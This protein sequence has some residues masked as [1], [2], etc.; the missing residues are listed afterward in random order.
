MPNDFT[1]QEEIN[2]EKAMI[3]MQSRHGDRYV[4]YVTLWVRQPHL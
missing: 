1:G 4:Q 2:T 3:Q